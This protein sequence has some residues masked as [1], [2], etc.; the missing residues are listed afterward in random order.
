MED[1]VVEGFS[2]RV[3]ENLLRKLTSAPEDGKEE[4]RVVVESDR[5]RQ[6]VEAVREEERNKR[7]QLLER[8]RERQQRK[9]RQRE[10]RETALV[11]ALVQDLQRSYFRPKMKTI[12]C[13]SERKACIECYRENLSDPLRCAEAVKALSSCARKVQLDRISSEAQ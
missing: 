12:L 10:E 6:L 7:R 5:D 8:F 3:S 13:E 11:Q 9:S 2:L 4:S 1:E